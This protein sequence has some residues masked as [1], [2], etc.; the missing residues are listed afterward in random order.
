MLDTLIT[1]KTRIKLLLKFFLNSNTQS[2]LRSLESEF[3]E[4][5]NA[6][7]LELNRFEEAGLLKASFSGNK[8][9]FQANTEHPFFKEINSILQ[10]F[11][12][13]DR[14]LEKVTSHIGEL[15]EAYLTGEVAKGNDSNIIDLVLVGNNLDRMY[16]TSLVEKTESLIHRKI[17]FLLVTE[18]EKQ[19]ILEHA[20]ALL[21][22]KS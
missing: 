4:S 15:K 18:S 8:K 1:N 7:R 5:S 13:I 3:G 19:A 12:G 21:I 11:V 6:I 22:W 17:R 20:P 9:I 10:K 16:I 2:Y 14:I